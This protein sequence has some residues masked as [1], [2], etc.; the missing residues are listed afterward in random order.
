MTWMQGV[1]VK[2]LLGNPIIIAPSLTLPDL[3]I[4]TSYHQHL[5]CTK[6]KKMNKS[7]QRGAKGAMNSNL[8]IS[9]D[10]PEHQ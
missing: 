4:F 3:N 10:V 2:K 5:A 6:Y 7:V 9:G 1:L 8:I